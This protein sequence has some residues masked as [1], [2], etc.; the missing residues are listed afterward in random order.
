MKN[1]KKMFIPLA[2]GDTKVRIR[3]WNYLFNAEAIHYLDITGYF[4]LTE[5]ESTWEK[6]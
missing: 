5:W 4:L 2:T 3:F 1:E 6:Q